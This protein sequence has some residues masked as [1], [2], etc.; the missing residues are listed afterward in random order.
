MINNINNMLNSLLGGQVNSGN[1]LNNIINLFQQRQ[2]PVNNQGI[3]MPTGDSL[4]LS[5]T[6][7]IQNYQPV[8]DISFIEYI[9]P[10][11][12][13]QGQ[14]VLI[15]IFNKLFDIDN[16]SFMEVIDLIRQM[17]PEKQS[18][19]AMELDKALRT[20]GY[21]EDISK[22][23]QKLQYIPA[24]KQELFLDKFKEFFTANNI[25][26]PEN[27]TF[28]QALNL[29]D[30]LNDSN[31]ILFLNYINKFI[32]ISSLDNIDIPDGIFNNNQ[33]IKKYINDL[34]RDKWGDA[35]GLPPEIS[36]IFNMPNYLQGFATQFGDFTFLTKLA[37][38]SLKNQIY[39]QSQRIMSAVAYLNSAEL[40]PN[41]N[42]SY[43]EGM[44]KYKDAPP[45]LRAQ[46]DAIHKEL[47][48]NAMYYLEQ[49]QL[50]LEQTSQG[51]N[52]MVS[53]A[54]GHKNYQ[55]NLVKNAI[56]GNG[57]Q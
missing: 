11:L 53:L 38:T 46:Y 39:L 55:D 3:Y 47:I 32:D 18:A 9:A 35:I 48:R 14:A 37:G 15:N 45:A 49:M 24:N 7:S 17:S 25:N 54:E 43:I 23:I 28:T 52:N 56:K 6:N 21:S 27:L 36:G 22:D 29:L 50:R 16:L 42:F 44:P 4:A 57:G 10:Q 13:E 20:G 31:K 26:F 2:Q 51:V 40:K 41:P 30:S 1:P 8:L 34:G 19:F 33:D 12:T 5:A